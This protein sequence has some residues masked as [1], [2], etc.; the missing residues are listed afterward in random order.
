MNVEFHEWYAYRLSRMMAFKVYGHAGKIMMIFPSSGGRFH[1]AEDFGI[2]HALA[3][4][5]DNG[6]I[7]VVTPDSIDNE[8]WLQDGKTAKDKAIHH[9]AYDAYIVEELCPFI[10]QHTGNTDRFIVSGCS[11]GAY[12]GVN[13]FF[14]HPDVFDT[15]IALSGIY[16]ARIHVGEALHE[17][18]VYF[19]SPIDYLKHLEDP[20]YLDAYRNSTI[21]IACGQGA[22]EAD[23]ITDTRQMEWILHEQA[24]PAWIDFWGEDVH[25]DWEWWR[26]MMPYYVGKLEE[27][28]VIGSR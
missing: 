8:T 22:Y 13:F 9:N 14:R 10:R 2:I 23:A 6:L 21:I 26:K 4:F 28:G 27:F 11:M 19:N 16:D 5:I 15:L 1:E 20:Y 24:I 3:Y 18:E 17:P 25:H 7:R 12:H